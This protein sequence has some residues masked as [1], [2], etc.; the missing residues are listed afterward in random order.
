MSSSS[1]KTPVQRP[2]SGQGRYLLVALGIP[3]VVIAVGLAIVAGLWSSIPPVVAS[4]WGRGGVD[5]TQSR[6]V[7]VVT[8]TV[9]ILAL[10]ALLALAGWFMPADGRRLLATVSGATSAFLAVVLFGVLVGQRG[11]NDPSTASAAPQM[12]LVGALAAAVVGWAAWALTSQQPATV[13]DRTPV[14]PDAP[15]V[16]AVDGERL[17]WFGHA[18]G[19]PWLGW[20][21]VLLVAVACFS[22]V[23]ASPWAALGPVLGIVLIVLLMRAR[24][25]VD[26]QGLRVVSGGFLTW[27]SVPIDQVAYAEVAHL[28]AFKEFGGLGMRY[29]RDARAFV[30]RTGEALRVVQQDGTRTYVSLDG[31]D[32]AAAVLNTLTRRSVPS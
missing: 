31:A 13:T 8:A 5:A 11:Q 30:T 26:S 15:T 18:A 23:V 12:F 1:P 22:A 9:V 24:V 3:V 29:R 27:L 10:G 14:P 17:A 16:P 6:V 21:C 19:A 25:T 4:H 32:E 20:V 7:F 2:G 28:S